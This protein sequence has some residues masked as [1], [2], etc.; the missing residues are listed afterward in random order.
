[1]AFAPPNPQKVK[2]L[3]DKE[4]REMRAIRDA[5]VEAE[6]LQNDRKQQL[7]KCYQEYAPLQL[8]KAGEMMRCGTGVYG[9]PEVIGR[10]K[11]NDLLVCRRISA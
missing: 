10:S 3:R 7:R 4:A 9:P 2:F 1:M 5:V 8:V 11:G 6:R